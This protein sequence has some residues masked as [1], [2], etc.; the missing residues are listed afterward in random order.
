MVW[1]KDRRRVK[2]GRS[3]GVRQWWRTIRVSKKEDDKKEEACTGIETIEACAER[4][5]IQRVLKQGVHE[6]SGGGGWRLTEWIQFVLFWLPSVEEVAWVDMDGGHGNC[7]VI[8]VGRGGEEALCRR[9][10]EIMADLLSLIS[11]HTIWT[12]E[13]ADATKKKKPMTIEE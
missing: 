6:D 12:K 11:G 2:A 4:R 10:Q 8:M 7:Q 1:G 3:S 13:E 9:G 5:G